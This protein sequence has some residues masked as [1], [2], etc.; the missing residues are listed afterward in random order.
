MKSVINLVSQVVTDVS[1]LSATDHIILNA[2]SLVI[3]GVHIR[4]ADPEDGSNVSFDW[5]VQTHEAFVQFY[6]GV[7]CHPG[8]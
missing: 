1:V 2:Q 7:Q 5:R 6:S 3:E 4:L 8:V